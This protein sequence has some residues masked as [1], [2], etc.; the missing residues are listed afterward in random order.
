MITDEIVDFVRREMMCYEFRA[1]RAL[2]E[3]RE[4]LLF[5]AKAIANL[6]EKLCSQEFDS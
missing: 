5:A 6:L 3:K 2:G 1:E 4:R